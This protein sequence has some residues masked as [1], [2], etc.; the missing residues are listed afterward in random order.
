MKHTTD[1]AA[2]TAALTAAGSWIGW[3]PDL[4]TVIVGVLSGVWLAIRIYDRIRHGHRGKE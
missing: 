1:G 3:I 4:V 2:L